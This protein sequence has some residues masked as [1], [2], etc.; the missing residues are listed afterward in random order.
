MPKHLIL[1][2]A[3]YPWILF[4]A[5]NIHFPWSGAVAQRIEPNTFFDAIGPTAGNGTIERR[6]FEVASYG[7]QLGL[8]MEV[9]VDMA[10]KH[11]TGSDQARHSL[12]RIQQIQSRIEELKKSEVASITDQIESQLTQL[13]KRNPGEFSI[14][15]TRLL[16]VLREADA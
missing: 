16:R 14:L 12:E 9:V 1:E 2:I 10:Q 3:M 8:L 13:K 5:P 15:K 7:R 11:G 6:A 4:W